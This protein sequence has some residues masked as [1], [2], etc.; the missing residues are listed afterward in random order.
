MRETIAAIRRRTAETA[1]TR[2]SPSWNGPEMRPGK[3]S[4][5]VSRFVFAGLSADSAPYRDSR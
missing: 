2:I 3:N 1:N 5:P 4:R